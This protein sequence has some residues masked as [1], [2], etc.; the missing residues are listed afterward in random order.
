MYSR[1]E[2]FQEGLLK[3]LQ[4]RQLCG[5]TLTDAL[6]IYDVAE[7]N[8][9][10]EVRFVD[11]PSLEEMYWKDASRIFISAMRPVGRQ[12]FNCAHGLGHHVFG[13]GNCIASISTNG[14]QPHFNEQ[15][16]LADAF[17]ASFL[18]PRTTVSHG[19]ASRGW[20]LG[21]CMPFQ[22][23]V[24]ASW[25]GVGYETLI[26]HMR[27]TLHLLTLEQAEL[28]LK[29]EPKNIR[30]DLIGE[31]TNNNVI[32]VDHCWTGRPIDLA[33]GDLLMLP[34]TGGAVGREVE[35]IETGHK[36]KLFRAVTPG[37]GSRAEIGADWSAF[38]RVAR[39]QYCGR[40]L[41]RNLDDPDYAN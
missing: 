17:A 7:A 14:S 40:N 9:I 18:M 33:V 13:H 16:F 2:L 15:E 5:V 21:Q 38:I 19:F 27:D 25:L 11:I 26:H 29:K 12:A 39:P 34:A 35:L 10:S 4:L 23:Y 37:A 24:V 22:I 41:F 36:A 8:G 6:C 28:L 30:K 31:E 3:A 32:V 1:K 20:A